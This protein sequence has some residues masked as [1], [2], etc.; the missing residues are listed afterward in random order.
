MVQCNPSIDTD[1]ELMNYASSF[2]FSSSSFCFMYI[3]HKIGNYY[4]VLLGPSE[5][6]DLDVLTFSCYIVLQFLGE[7][8]K[9]KFSDAYS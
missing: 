9:N 4:N 2:V 8:R 3:C 1:S 7:N 5:G 6:N